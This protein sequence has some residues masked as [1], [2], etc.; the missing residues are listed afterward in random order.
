MI[1]TLQLSKILY[2]SVETASDTVNYITDYIN[3][4]YCQN[5]TVDIT[6]LNLLDS[7]YV[8]TICSSKHFLKYPEGKIKWIVSSTAT[9]K[10]CKPLNL[11][12]CEYIAL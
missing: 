2:P 3:D 4:N 12:N 6:G 9:E 5:L 7:C 11:G 1:N 8:S 10:M